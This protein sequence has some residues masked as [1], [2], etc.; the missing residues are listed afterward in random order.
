MYCSDC[1]GADNET[2]GDPRG[3]HG[4]NYKYMLKGRGKYWPTDPNGYLWRLNSTDASNSDL[5]CNNCHEIYNNGW[6]NNAH[7]DM[8]NQ[9]GG[10]GGMTLSCVTCHVAVPHGSKRSRLIGY[11]TDPAPY[12]YNG[13][14]LKLRGFHKALGANAYTCWNCHS[15]SCDSPTG[16]DP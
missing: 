12:N 13:N 1:H 16:C 3:P 9:G 4:S 11:S 14:S 8:A 7:A 10:M 2:S 5:F 6:T 15:S